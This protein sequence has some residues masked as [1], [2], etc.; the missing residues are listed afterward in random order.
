MARLIQ[1]N[2]ERANHQLPIPPDD[3]ADIGRAAVLGFMVYAAI[4]EERADRYEQL[5]G[6]VFRLL[7]EPT[8][9]E[10]LPSNK[11]ASQTCNKR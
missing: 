5:I 1:Q 10:L 9:G 8:A 2:M 6:T 7:A 3:L 11:T 4:D